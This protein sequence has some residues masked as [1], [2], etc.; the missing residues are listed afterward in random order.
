M[1][2]L[3]ASSSV[4]YRRFTAQ[5]LINPL[6]PGRLEERAFSGKLGICL[7]HPGMIVLT[8]SLLGQALDSRERF[9]EILAIDD[10]DCEFINPFAAV[11]VF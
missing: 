2:V 7:L 1:F 9:Y 11:R 3:Q 8:H 5:N 4:V 6:L 10:H